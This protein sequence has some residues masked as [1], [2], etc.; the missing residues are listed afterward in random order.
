MAAAQT[1]ARPTAILDASAVMAVIKGEAGWEMVA[2]V[3]DDAA[4]PAVNLAECAHLL[5]LGKKFR[6]FTPREIDF[7]LQRFRTVDV[8][9]EMGLEV[10]RIR[11]SANEGKL[12]LGDVMCLATASVM[13]LPVYTSDKE[14]ET[15]GPKNVTVI[16]VR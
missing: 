14:W 11:T 3:L 15:L 1:P 2:A 16:Q 13:K 9:R 12:S 5:A 4:V 8:T 10:G 7:V 6:K